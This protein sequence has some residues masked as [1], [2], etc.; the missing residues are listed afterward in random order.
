MSIANYLGRKY[1][2]FKNPRVVCP[3]GEI[4]PGEG[5]L[6]V[7]AT[8]M[9]SGTH[10]MID[11][12]LNNFPRYKRRPLY[13]DL[14]RLL[15]AAD[16]EEKVDKLLASGGYVVKTH[17]PQAFDQ[18]G[19][20]P[21][22]RRVAER[23]RIVV[24]HRDPE[25]TYRSLQAWTSQWDLGLVKDKGAYLASVARFG[26]F[27]RDYPRLDFQFEE[28]VDEKGYEDMVGRLQAFLGTPP[29]ARL[30]RPPRASARLQVY[31]TK[32]LTRVLGHRAPV[33]NTT[34]RFG[35]TGS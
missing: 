29:S 35:K 31:L 11:T 22:V 32:G 10:L 6:V 28:L 19:R 25:R 21:L 2:R 3:P 24:V 8:V 13:V 5:P 17:F 27:W 9:R 15:D 33:V 16:R 20:E 30:R 18:P 26:E 34:I 12:I 23:S 1:L 7:V 4:L 14:D